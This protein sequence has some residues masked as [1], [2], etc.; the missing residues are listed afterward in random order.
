MRKI[1]DSIAH[2]YAREAFKDH[3]ES[4]EA[5]D[6]FVKEIQ[7]DRNRKKFLHIGTIY[8]FLVKCGD[9]TVNVEES[10]A[11]IDYF[12]NSYKLVTLFSL[13]ES[14]ST[15]RYVD[16]F[17]WLNLK[18]RKRDFPLERKDL[19]IKYEEYKFE[20]GSIKKCK[21]FFEALP[22]S[23]K[24]RLIKSFSLKSGELTIEEIATYLYNLRSKFV[25]EAEFILELGTIPHLVREDDSY[26]LIKLS[27]KDFMN[28][29]ELG[30]IE[31]FNINT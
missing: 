16:F 8:L 2:K 30:I 27:L 24:A 10:N 25:H 17:Q 26:T 28:V 29:F 20:Y 12:T 15:E 6:T 21:A 31:Y 13:I 3:F 14:L 4:Q 18:E 1:P 23:E 9:W 11:V 5:F 7:P 19:G 22:N